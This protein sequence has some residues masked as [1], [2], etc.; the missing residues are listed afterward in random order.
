G[1]RLDERRVG[2]GADPDAEL[3][4]HAGGRDRALPASRRLAA[5]V[6]HGRQQGRLRRIERPEPPEQRPRLVE[7]AELYVRLA[8][9]LERLRV[10]G[11][12]PQGLLVT[13]DRRRVVLLHAEGVAEPVP[14]LRER[15]PEPDRVA[16]GRLGAAP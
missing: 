1:P 16:E 14:R 15:R 4:G 6:D 11:A 5:A 9:I 2:P 7:L 12:E 10:I 3:G 13:L 8:E